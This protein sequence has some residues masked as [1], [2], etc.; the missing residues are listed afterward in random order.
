MM[1]QERLDFDM[2]KREFVVQR[3]V[4]EKHEKGTKTLF[5]KRTIR[6]LDMAVEAYERQLQIAPLNNGKLWLH[7]CSNEPIIVYE[8]VNNALKT[9]CKK[10]DVRYRPSKQLRHSYASNRIMS[11]ANL[12]DVAEQMG[13][14][15][16]NGQVSI[17][18]LM[19]HYATYIKQAAGLECGSYGKT[20][21][22]SHVPLQGIER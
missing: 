15:K 12:Y 19:K 21:S 10:A 1:G 4:V 8:H 7:P 3:A 9:I 16:K 11:G 5:S 14:K 20:V 2:G 6:M 13:H 22:K 18:M 17:E